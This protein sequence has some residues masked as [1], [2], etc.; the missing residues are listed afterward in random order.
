MAENGFDATVKKSKKNKRKNALIAFVCV[1]L[2]LAA[3]IFYC[4]SELFFVK[5][6]S[7]KNTSEDDGNGAF[8]YSD[9]EMLEG[10][11]IKT[12]QQLYGFDVKEAQDNAI[13]NLAYI[14]DIKLSRR[15]PS[16][17][18][19][20]VEL[21]NPSFYVSVSDDLYILSDN[22]KVLE[23]TGN[24][25]KIEVSSL[26]L[27]QAGKIDNCIVGEKLGNVNSVCYI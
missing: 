1:C 15:W 4:M 17:V 24:V 7:V 18:V 26:I 25:E 6:I 20:K 9:E 8:P 13:Y 16:T 27:L 12:G 23:R 11:G 21:E 2:V 19:A 5:S 14:K 10:L 3:G 22:L